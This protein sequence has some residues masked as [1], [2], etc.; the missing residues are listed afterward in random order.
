MKIVSSKMPIV[1]IF[2]EVTPLMAVVYEVFMKVSFL[3]ELSLMTEIS[4]PVSTRKV[5]S[6]PEFK[7]FV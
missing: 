4:A 7:V 3:I 5:V 6:L 2:P 1:L